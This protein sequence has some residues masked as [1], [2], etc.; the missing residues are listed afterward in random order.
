MCFLTWR[1]KLLELCWLIVWFLTLYLTWF[2]LYRS[3]QCTHLC[4][5][6]L[7][8]T[9]TTCIV[10]YS[11]WLLSNSHN[12][13][14]INEHQWERNESFRSDCHEFL[15]RILAEMKVWTSDPQFS[16]PVGYQLRYGGS[17]KIIY[18][19]NYNMKIMFIQYDNVI[20]DVMKNR[21]YQ[22]II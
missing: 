18:K 20:S 1:R 8:F 12:H 17:I 11:H 13:H 5:P 9:S 22:S 14:E 7:L 19:V 6:G 2:Q 16:N 4:F 21:P 10:L 3:A 15:E